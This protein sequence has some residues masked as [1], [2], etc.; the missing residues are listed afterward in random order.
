M[1]LGVGSSGRGEGSGERGEGSSGSHGDGK[2][3]AKNKPKGGRG[4]RGK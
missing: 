2:N 4:K 1:H 3:T